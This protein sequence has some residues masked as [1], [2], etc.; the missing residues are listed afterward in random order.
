MALV[1]PGLAYAAP[2]ATPADRFERVSTD[3]IDSSF[4]PA[5]ASK[6]A[7]I[8]AMV[9]LTAEPVA[10]VA[11]ES[12]QPLTEAQKAQVV[13]KIK[14]DQDVV[15]GEV[16]AVGGKVESQM[17]SAYNGMRVAVKRSELDALAGLPQV[18]AIH[19]VVYHEPGNATSIP[20]LGVQ[21]VWKNTGYTGKNVKV[22]VIDTGI[23]Y[24][25]AT[26]GGPGTVAA[27]TAA[28][29][30]S[31]TPADP[32]LF[33]PQ[34]PRVK[35]GWDFVGD[36]YNGKDKVTPAPDANP[37]DCAGHG[38]HV[39]GSIGGGGVNV[40]GN[41]FTGPYNETT[42]QRE[43]RVGPG[44]AP[45][46]DLYAL[47][48]FGCTGST[49]VT[50]EAIDW[51]VK[52]GMD[53]I[54]MSLGSSYGTSD[55]SSAVAATNAAA[56]GVVVVASAGNSGANPYLVGSPSTGSGVISVAA[57]DPAKS[58]P[59]A[60]ITVGGQTI[61]AVN[62]NGATLPTTPFT[63][64]VLKDDPA[65]PANEALGCSVDAY[66]KNGISPTA[67]PKQIAVTKRGTCARV[68]RGVYGQQAGAGAVLMINN[69]DSM[70][71]YEGRITSNPDTGAAYDVTIPFLGV[72]L[73]KGAALT[74]GSS[75][76]LASAELPNPTFGAFGSFT[77]AGPRTGDSG[78]KPSVT[79]PGVSIVSA[80]FGTGNAPAVMSGTSMAAPMV[81]GVAALTVQSHPKWSGQ[82]R[83][84]A[85]VG[86]ARPSKVTDYRLTRG[87]GLVDPAAAVAASSVVL[88]DSYRTDSGRYRETALSFGFTE[89]NG[90]FVGTKLVTIKNNGSSSETYTIS[91]TPTTQSLPARVSVGTTRV[92]VPPRQ[93][94]AVP[95]TLVVEARNVPSSI[96]DG[97]Q[98]RFYEVSG[99]VSVVGSK[100]KATMAIPY[101]LVPRSLSG[102]LA[103]QTAR[104]GADSAKVSLV[105][106]GLTRSGDADFY[107]WGLSDPQDID[108]KSFD[109]SHDIRAVGVSS[110]PV[111]DDQLL[112]FAINGYNRFSNVAGTEFDVPIDVNGDGKADYTVFS[113]D[114]G[115]I[116][117]GYTDG[118]A[119]VFIFNNATGSL[120]PSG[121]LTF[122]PTDSSTLL[123]PVRASSVGVKQASGAFSYTAVGFSSQ[124]G[125]ADEVAGWASYNPWAKAISNGDYVTV[126]PFRT[127]S[128]TLTID[129]AQLAIQK[130]LGTMVVVFD[131]CAGR[132]EAITLPAPK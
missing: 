40:D 99:N 39:A 59:G 60:K 21:E 127:A 15:K 89:I 114:S 45:Q 86:T 115:A 66:T 13:T 32:A 17:Q 46:V 117:T 106:L 102:V 37:L 16:A 78:L 77:S 52:N 120:A 34:S 113:Y 14:A 104:T 25:H 8:Q 108:A 42:P 61:D 62:A 91:A 73:S 65:T 68:A 43:F 3:K 35:G 6:D 33:G 111:G 47:K 44:I 112:V 38:T 64:V 22:A 18:K 24:T 129:R 79:A 101:L 4:V 119:E 84:A 131:N 88:G 53:V 71:P 128:Q 83:T 54:N 19:K 12:D 69:T 81:A 9:E 132:M 56:A 109:R 5:S 87:G 51:A 107:T 95:V 121:F 28:R 90:L 29:A 27:Y 85:I 118:K 72:P 105:N 98:S 26:F 74:D 100:S 31:S 103:S 48:V 10:V 41:A 97:S 1:T 20:Y 63:V 82:D 130:P 126:N 11:A 23:D 7:V 125:A 116:R 30:A 92:T 94:R 110:S 57:N 76:T 96:A 49:G 75:V 36:E 70:P 123:L 2:G 67:D 93:S 122:A 80:G 50:T 124:S 58:F 55:D